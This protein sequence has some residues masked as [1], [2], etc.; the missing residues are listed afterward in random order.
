MTSEIGLVYDFRLRW[1]GIAAGQG[2]GA[3]CDKAVDYSLVVDVAM[4]GL[5]TRLDRDTFMAGERGH[6][7]NI[8]GT[9]DA[10]SC[11]MRLLYNDPYA[12]RMRM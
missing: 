11:I 10:S 7:G 6:R 5:H 8:S 1:N 12:F 2:Q 4:D 9:Y 3:R